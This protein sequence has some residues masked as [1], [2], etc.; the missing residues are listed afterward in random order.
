MQLSKDYAY[1]SNG[2]SIGKRTS[3]ATERKVV[4]LQLEQNDV[5]AEWYSENSWMSESEINV[6]SAQSIPWRHC[7]VQKSLWSFVGVFLNTWKSDLFP[8]QKQKWKHST[9][10]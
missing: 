6:K 1:Y 2:Q 7:A 5:L 4:I 3:R 9:C 8:L 10:K